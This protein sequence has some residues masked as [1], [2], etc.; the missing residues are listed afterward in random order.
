MSKVVDGV[1]R[2]KSV[3]KK[4]LKKIVEVNNQTFIRYFKIFINSV[5]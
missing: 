1:S 4:I 5:N 3:E 2:S